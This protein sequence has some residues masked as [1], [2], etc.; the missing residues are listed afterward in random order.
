MSPDIAKCFLRGEISQ[1]ENHWSKLPLS[2][3]WTWAVVSLPSFLIHFPI[4]ATLLFSKDK[5]HCVSPVLNRHFCASHF[6]TDTDSN[7][8]YNLEGP[9]LSGPNHPFSDSFSLILLL[10]LCPKGTPAFFQFL[11]FVNL[12]VQGLSCGI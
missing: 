8:Q 10:T 6:S 9:A 1:F 7:P 4:A 2:L 3:S 11:K 5:S 12:A